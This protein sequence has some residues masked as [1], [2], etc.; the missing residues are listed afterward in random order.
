MTLEFF[1]VHRILI[2]KA[3]DLVYKENEI[4]TTQEL[5]YGIM[6]L[7]IF[8]FVLKPIFYHIYCN[9]LQVIHKFTGYIIFCIFFSISCVCNN[10]VDSKKCCC[11]IIKVCI[12]SVFPSN[13]SAFFVCLIRKNHGYNNNQDN[14]SQCVCITYSSVLNCIHYN[15]PSSMQQSMLIY[16][17]KL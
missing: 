9:E 15:N 3:A 13:Q 5:Y 4:S 8:L 7:L 16:M 1:G 10:S 11:S 6:Y 2:G 17:T 12:H 14:N